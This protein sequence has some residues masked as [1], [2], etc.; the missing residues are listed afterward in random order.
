MLQELFTLPRLS[1]TSLAEITLPQIGYE[2]L[3]IVVQV[4]HVQ[5]DLYIMIT[6]FIKLINFNCQYM[7]RGEI[8]VPRHQLSSLLEAAST[9]KI[10]GIDNEN[11]NIVI[12]IQI[13][14]MTSPLNFRS[15]QPTSG[16]HVLL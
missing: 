6:C 7:Y 12:Q 3:K 11:I 9:L 16:G 14:V 1:D 15:D 4:S 13:K 5:L 8:T 2:D 10:P